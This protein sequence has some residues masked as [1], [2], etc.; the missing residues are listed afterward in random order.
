LSETEIQP[1]FPA[2]LDLSSADTR[3]NYMENGWKDAVVTNVT[4][5]VTTNPDGNLPVGTP[6]INVEF[7]IDGGQYNDRRVWNRYWFPP[8]DYDPDK[9]A[10]TLNILARFLK[11]IGYT[12]EDIKRPD[13]ALEPENMVGQE[14][15]VNTKY[16]EDYDNNKVNGVKPR[17]AGDATSTGAGLL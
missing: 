5:I 10:K 14:V 17:S 12:D 2:T 11:G 13:F 1:E 3:G 7:T 9:R 16:D 6:G 4:P 8:A 15:K